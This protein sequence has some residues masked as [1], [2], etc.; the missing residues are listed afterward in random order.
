MEQESLLNLSPK[1]VYDKI[2]LIAV[3]D[4]MLYL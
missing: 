3:F 4:W 1:L 2:S